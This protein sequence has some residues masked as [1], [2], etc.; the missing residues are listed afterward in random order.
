MLNPA[1]F[2]TVFIKREYPCYLSPHSQGLASEIADHAF[3]ERAS[4]PVTSAD[5]NCA[6]L[7][8]YGPLRRCHTAL[9]LYLLL[10]T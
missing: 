8:N 2:P 9:Q 4:P 10:G 1:V 6:V 7:V 3:V 5:A